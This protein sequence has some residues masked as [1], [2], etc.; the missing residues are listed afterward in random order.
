MGI[1]V[2]W[3]YSHAEHTTALCWMQQYQ[4]ADGL[5]CCSEQDCLP[6]PVALLHTIADEVMVRIGDTMVPLLAKSVH[7]TQNGQP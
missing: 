2:L 6:W 5:G 7:T 3:E 1:T 4:S